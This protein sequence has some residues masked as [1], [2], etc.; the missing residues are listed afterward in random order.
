MSRIGEWDGKNDICSKVILIF[1]SVYDKSV[2]KV[3]YLLTFDI[4]DPFS[5]NIL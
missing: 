2:Y 4:A 1:K 3:I 5:I